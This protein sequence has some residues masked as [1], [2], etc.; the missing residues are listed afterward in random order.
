ML[1]V[2]DAPATFAQFPAVNEVQP[3]YFLPCSFSWGDRQPIEPLGRNRP[4]VIGQCQ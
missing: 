2:L 4:A 1:L 3:G